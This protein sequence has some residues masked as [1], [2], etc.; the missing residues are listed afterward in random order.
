MP[1]DREFLLYPLDT[2]ED[3]L[4][5]R[6]RHPMLLA[7]RR[8]KASRTSL[9]SGASVAAARKSSCVRMTPLT[10]RSPAGFCVQG[11]FDLLGLARP[12]PGGDANGRI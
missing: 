2:G 12:P 10:S 5:D 8:E 9:L 1:P 6:C 7:T 3:P 4:C 11:G